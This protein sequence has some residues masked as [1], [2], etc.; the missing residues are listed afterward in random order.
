MKL[1]EF[2][3]IDERHARIADVT[4]GQPG[5]RLRSSCPPGVEK[6]YFVYERGIIIARIESR[7]DTHRGRENRPAFGQPEPIFELRERP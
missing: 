3:T 7:D 5:V 2:D 4:Y 6:K 1:V